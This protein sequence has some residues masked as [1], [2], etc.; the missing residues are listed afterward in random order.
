MSTGRRLSLGSRVKKQVDCVQAA[1]ELSP[2][3]LA[4]SVP[5]PTQQ[6]ATRQPSPI[7]FAAIFCWTMTA[8]SAVMV[9]IVRW[10]LGSPHWFVF[11]KAFLL[12]GA[13]I[14]CATL[15]TV[16]QV[17]RSG[18]Y[19]ALLV[20]TVAVIFLPC[21]AWLNGPLADF[22]TYP[23]FLGLLA[24]GISQA[25][26]ATR[27]APA[28]R[29]MFAVVCGCFAGFGYFL[30]I[31][32]RAYASVLTPE[33]AL[34]GIH[35][36]DTI[37]HVSIANM[38]VKYGVLSTGLDGLVPT[39]YHVLSHIWLG[40]VSLWLGVSTLEG[41]YI[42][43]QVIAIPMLLFS[44][45]LAIHLFRRSGEG[46]A[47]G[48]LM[49]LGSLLLLFVA[50]LRGWT[51]YLVSE[52]YFLAMILFL[53]TLPL[54]AEIA[55]TERRH[56]LSLQLAALGVVGLLILLSKISVGAVL[57]GGVGFLL[58]RRMGMTTLGLITL[59]VPLLLLVVLAIAVISP[60]AGQLLQSL[61]PLGF[62]RE[63]PRGALPNIAANLV[64]L[65]VAFQVWRR[66]TERDKRCAEAVGVMAIAGITVA[67]LAN[68]P[69]GADYY[70]VNVGT[71][72]AIVFV[73]AYG[74][75]FFEKTFANPL[76]PGFVVAA[77]LLVAFATEEKRKS[78]YRLGA[79]FAELQARVRL[80]TGE[81]AGVET[82]TGQR[83]VALL[84]PGHRARYALASD[85][86]RTPG[87][88]AKETLLAM[89]IT[90]AHRGAVF[91]PP[92]NVAFWTI[93][94]ECRSDPFFVPAILGAPML[95]GLNPLALK[96]PREPYYGFANYRDAHSES[97]SDQQLC[98]SAA[99]WKIDTVFILTTRSTG[100]RIR[101]S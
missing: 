91:V 48:A 59:A 54:L 13:V 81:S 78:A 61:E 1:E 26:S 100:R 90:Q 101:C 5:G 22:V 31:N 2:R 74:G 83:L 88:Q 63:H 96:C 64:L 69:G 16:Q 36:L 20:S 82:T 53:L 55:D 86:K 19:S 79:M 58:W 10:P 46:P 3:R 92:D 42:S 62:I 35:Q 18:A 24:T 56:R 65:G 67:L 73:C 27:A 6:L 87:A 17:E 39:K 23:L 28:S 70:F 33:L 51:H 11:V 32:S 38:L 76:M 71:W 94:V 72:A 25:A 43:G 47:S 8:V 40:C 14:A 21:L 66:G 80:V 84:T 9:A 49:T 30:V 15:L 89:G 50:D 85:M 98:A 37:F 68:L 93:A 95:K 44:L 34:A 77:I 97:L 12:P 7:Y 4:E 60:G 52:S 45:S 57:S 29:W 75:T 99:P 41:Y